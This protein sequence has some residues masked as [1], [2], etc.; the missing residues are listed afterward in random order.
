MEPNIRSRV[1]K[2]QLLTPDP[3]QLSPF[4]NLK[5]DIVFLKY[6]RA[7]VSTDSVSAAYRGPKKMEN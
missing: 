1:H 7:P 6:S 3:S 4:S 2:S 5:F